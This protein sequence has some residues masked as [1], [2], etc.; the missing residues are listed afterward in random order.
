MDGWLN[1]YK[2]KGVSSAKAVA[3]VK[4]YFKNS[5]IGHTGTLDLEAEGVLPIAIGQAT[6]LVSI[7][8][9]SLKSIYLLS[10]S[11]LKLIPVTQLGKLLKKRILYPQKNNVWAYAINLSVKSNRYLQYI[12]L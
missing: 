6:K 12:R 2:P 7:L 8:I 1:L 5:R 4:S 9:D 11:V 10:N 3:V